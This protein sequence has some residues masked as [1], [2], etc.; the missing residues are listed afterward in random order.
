MRFG[1][2]CP[3]AILQFGGLRLARL[4][5]PEQTARPV[6]KAVHHRTHDHAF[7]A[8]SPSFSSSFSLYLL[9]L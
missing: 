7:P 8:L 2:P 5:D 6:P 3:S 1:H 4:R 9:V